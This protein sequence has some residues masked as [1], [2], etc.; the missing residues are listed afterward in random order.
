MPDLFDAIGDRFHNL[1]AENPQLADA[2]GVVPDW[3]PKRPAPLGDHPEQGTHPSILRAMTV[4]LD[5][6]PEAVR[7][8]ALVQALLS[9]NPMGQVSAISEIEGATDLIPPGHPLAGEIQAVLSNASLGTAYNPQPEKTEAMAAR[10]MDESGL[11]E[12][13]EDLAAALARGQGLHARNLPHT[14]G[15]GLAGTF[16]D[17][18]QRE[19]WKQRFLDPYQ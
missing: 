3:P 11:S 5:V 18:L 14:S 15:S 13:G 10:L 2:M 8:S 6:A 9:P 7:H 12:P 4:P 16:M 19:A 1:M 17:G